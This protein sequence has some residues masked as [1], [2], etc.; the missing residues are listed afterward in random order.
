M[1]LFS[2]KD[3]VLPF[4][5]GNRINFVDNN[6]YD[7]LPEFFKGDSPSPFRNMG[8]LYKDMIEPYVDE[9]V[10]C[11][12]DPEKTE[13][14]QTHNGNPVRALLKDKTV[15]K[16]IVEYFENLFNAKVNEIQV[17]RNFVTDVPSYLD[18]EECNKDNYWISQYWHID[19]YLHK[20][21]S[22]GIYLNDVEDGGG[23]FE[24]LNNPEYYFYNSK[25]GNWKTSRFN[26]L[27]PS[28]DEIT[29]ILG[30]RCTTFFF[31]PNFIHR[32][33]FSRTKQRDFIRLL[34]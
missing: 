19:N 17:N 21:F 30:P 2:N 1:K 24:Y 3:T 33:T 25:I 22:V 20:N 23:Q 9:I 10:D 18:V 14:K 16:Y 31:I 15:V 8:L 4:Y 5:E 32:G 28:E 29:K 27:Q 13:V 11:L 7:V 26:L 6:F 34:F 12:N